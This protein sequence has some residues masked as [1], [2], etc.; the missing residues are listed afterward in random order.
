M[1]N[2]P[3]SPSPIHRIV[4]HMDDTARSRERVAFAASLA[5]E[6]GSELSV[7]YAAMPG[8]ALVPYAPEGVGPA[9]ELLREVDDDRLRKARQLFDKACSEAAVP[10]SFAPCCDVPV[11][12]GY[13]APEKKGT[14]MP[15]QPI[16]VIEVRVKAAKQGQGI[17]TV[18]VGPRGATG[19]SGS[20]MAGRS[21]VV[22]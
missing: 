2:T 11:E 19:S 9:I 7:L 18:R 12:A 6:H 13:A 16:R 5:R 15:P 8:Y 4:A 10:V 3:S 14:P 21:F 1:S 22:E 20:A 17:M